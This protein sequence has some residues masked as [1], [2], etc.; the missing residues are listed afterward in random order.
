MTPQPAGTRIHDGTPSYDLTAWLAGTPHTWTSGRLI[1][2]GPDGDTRPE[3]GWWLIRWDDDLVT[4]ASPAVAERVYGTDGLWGRLQHAEEQLALN[5]AEKKQCSAQQWPQ[6]LARAETA[7]A[8]IQAIADDHPAGI[9]TA[10]IHAALPDREAATQATEPPVVDRQTA[11]V[12]A[13][14]HR[15]AE[16]DVSRVI[17]LYERW[18]KAGPPPLGTSVSRWWDKRLVELHA[19]LN[20]KEN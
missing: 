20:P 10:L 9:D 1:L 13:A 5:L 12:L 16:A 7:L 11:V 15:S 3:P 6:R 8:R 17:D 14:L 19:A 2:H 4:T 18:V